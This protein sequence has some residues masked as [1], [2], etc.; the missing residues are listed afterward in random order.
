M[1]IME[2]SR[3]NNQTKVSKEIITKKLNF[4]KNIRNNN[5]NKKM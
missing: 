3:I 2:L 5:K 1:A 4:T